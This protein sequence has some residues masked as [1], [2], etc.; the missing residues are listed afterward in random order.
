MLLFEDA[1]RKRFFRIVVKHLNNALSNNW[2]TIKC[3]V[4][5]MNGTAGPLNSM[6]DSLK[7]SVEPRKRRQQ[8]GMDIQD[9]LAESLQ[10]LRRQNAH[11]TGKANQVDV[12][13]FQ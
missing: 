4:N 12:V 8:A 6:F 5:E 10:K 2:P 9:A 11:V 1:C 3:F 7:L 13:L